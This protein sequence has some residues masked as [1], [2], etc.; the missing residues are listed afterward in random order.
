MTIPSFKV[1]NRVAAEYPAY[2]NALKNEELVAVLSA[3]AS[4]LDKKVK[5]CQGH[6]KYLKD[7]LPH[8]EGA[9]R[10][11]ARASSKHFQIDVS[12]KRLE[13]LRNLSS[14]FQEKIRL[15][16]FG[17]FIPPEQPVRGLRLVFI[18]PFKN[19]DRVEAFK[20]LK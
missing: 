16:K 10:S 18:P 4:E 15:E 1:S 14:L 8:K 7:S 6:I 17:Y 3:Y 5:K 9:K 20:L 11:R 2:A 13:T 19:W 12:T